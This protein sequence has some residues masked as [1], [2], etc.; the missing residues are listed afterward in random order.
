MVGTARKDLPNVDREMSTPF[1]SILLPVYNARHHL[2]QVMSDLLAQTFSNFEIIAVDDGSTDGS[3][4]LLKSCDDQRLRVI[5]FPE[6]RGLVATL[7]VGLSEAR[8]TWIARQDADDRCRG[9][10]L[11]LQRGL[12]LGN[13]DAVLVYSRARLINERGWWRGAMRPPL[14]EAGLRWDLCFRNTVPHTSAAFPTGLVRD[15]LNGYAGDNVTADFDLWSRLLRRGGA[16]G[17]GRSLVSYRN[18]AGSIMGRENASHAKP[19]TEGLREILLKNLIDW[20]G[21]VAD[22]ASIIAGAWLDPAGAD[23]GGYFEIRERLVSGRGSSVPDSLIAEED[24][25]L[26]YRAA[27]VSRHCAC[28]LLETMRSRFP[29]RYACLP[30]PKTLLGKILMRF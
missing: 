1:F 9:D 3:A 27:A 14:D 5:S 13:P 22:E 7:N 19:S 18:H 26:M 8:G 16:V 30:Q 25:A 21:A 10:R 28:E 11:E 29:Q 4:E 20:G 12:I 6:N 23:W 2:A 24:Y 17:D 15:E